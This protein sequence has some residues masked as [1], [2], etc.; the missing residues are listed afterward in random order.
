MHVVLKDTAAKYEQEVAAIGNE[1]AEGS[2][3]DIETSRHLRLTKAAEVRVVRNARLL[4]E[5]PALD[6]FG[7][8]T[9]AFDGETL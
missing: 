5:P 8:K 4:R 3:E 6:G 1:K 9:V 7:A 2:E